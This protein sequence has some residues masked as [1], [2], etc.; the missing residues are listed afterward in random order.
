MYR[1]QEHY[2][3]PRTPFSLKDLRDKYQSR[4][5]ILR[6]LP[7]FKHGISSPENRSMRVLLDL[8]LGMSFRLPFILFGVVSMSSAR[9]LFLHYAALRRAS[10]IFLRCRSIFRQCLRRPYLQELRTDRSYHPDDQHPAMYLQARPQFRCRY[11]DALSQVKTVQGAQGLR[12][13][14]YTSPVISTAPKCS[15]PKL[16]HP[17]SSSIVLRRVSASRIHGHSDYANLWW[18]QRYG[19]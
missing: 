5:K 6:S 13:Q 14:G 19:G 18:S 17:K 16:H 9:S 11:S 4:R 10:L 12:N 1:Y 2:D 8:V 15:K 3:L 7:L